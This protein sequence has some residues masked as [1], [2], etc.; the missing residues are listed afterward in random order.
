MKI[1]LAIGSLPRKK[2]EA[3]GF[4]EVIL[5]FNVGLKSYTEVKEEMDRLMHDG[6]PH[7]DGKHR[8]YRVT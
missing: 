6:A 1:R 7:F 2:V 5:Y 8:L 3:C 4:S